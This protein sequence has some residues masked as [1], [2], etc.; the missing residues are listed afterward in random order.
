MKVLTEVTYEVWQEGMLVASS[1]DISDATHYL[2]M[3]AQDGDA[4]LLKATTERRFLTEVRL[5]D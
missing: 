5:V 3:Y 1:S 2:T 4:Q